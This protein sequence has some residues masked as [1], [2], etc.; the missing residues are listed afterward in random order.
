[1]CLIDA[2][3]FFS[4]KQRNHSLKKLIFIQT[5]CA[6]HEK[7]LIDMKRFN[8]K[9]FVK[10]KHNLVCLISQSYGFKFERESGRDYS[11]ELRELVL[12]FEDMITTFTTLL[13][14][15]LW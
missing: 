9:G 10:K 11:L 2:P 13:Y 15:H 14:F 7:K 4:M 3:A 6:R 5:A 1:M 12:A 8:M